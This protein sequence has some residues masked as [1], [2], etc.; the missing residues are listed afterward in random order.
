MTNIRRCL[1]RNNSDDSYQFHLTNNKTFLASTRSYHLKVEL[2]Q[3]CI[4]DGK[5]LQISY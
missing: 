3:K 5:T 1:L 2:L 4:M